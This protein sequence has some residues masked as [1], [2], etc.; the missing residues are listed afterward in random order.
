M[1]DYRQ[2]STSPLAGNFNQA[3]QH[4]MLEKAE[5]CDCGKN[6]KKLETL[7][8]LKRFKQLVSHF[9]FQTFTFY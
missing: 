7:K 9:K 4:P 6:L 5:Q 2:N 8:K 3:A 1:A